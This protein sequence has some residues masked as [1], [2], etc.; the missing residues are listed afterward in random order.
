MTAWTS[1]DVRGGGHLGRVRLSGVGQVPGDKSLFPGAS[2][3]WKG[4]WEIKGRGVLHSPVLKDP[5]A[6]SCGLDWPPGALGPIAEQGRGSSDGL[7]ES[8]PGS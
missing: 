8:E 2:P 5:R 7:G 3:Q 1:G 6:Q 4:P